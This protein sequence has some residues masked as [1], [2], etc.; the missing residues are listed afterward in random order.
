MRLAAEQAGISS[1]KLSVALEP[2][3]ASLYCRHPPVL[4]DGPSGIFTF[5]TGKKY[6][7]LDAGGG[8]IDITVHEVCAGGN[9]KEIHRASGGDWG[10]T[11]IDG[12]FINFLEHIAGNTAMQ[13]FKDET[14]EDYLELLRD[15]EIKKRDIDVAS[16]TKVTIKVPSSL[17]DLV[18]EMTQLSIRDKLASSSYGKQVSLTG[19]KVRLDAD[20]MRSFFSATL[21]Q[22]ITHTSDLLEKP[23]CIGVE[24]IMM[25]GGFS[26]SKLLQEIFKMTFTQLKIIVPPEAGLAVLKGAVI[27]GHCPTA[28]TERIS[29]YT[30]GVASRVDFN[31]KIH[32]MSKRSV[33]EDGSIQCVNIFAI[34]VREGDKLV[35]GGA[36]KEKSFTV[37]SEC[38]KSVVVSIFSSR[39][40]NVKFIT[41]LGCKPVGTL[42]VPLAGR[43]TDRLV[44]VRMLFGG[45]EIIVE[46]VEEATNRIRRLNIDFL[47]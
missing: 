7:V 21:T 19:N 33:S 46:C 6:L 37:P 34:I 22:I 44:T 39:D 23:D 32:P 4:C 3:A 26:E 18:Q 20:V 28:I 42:E 15:F 13:R 27:Y 36:H 16:K 25:V 2:E 41:D 11:K 1:D 29:K 10:G 24:A 17:F 8:T 30:Y 45:T 31:E 14:M 43:G 40:R 38:K 12:A 9:L 5:Q 35:V 47:T